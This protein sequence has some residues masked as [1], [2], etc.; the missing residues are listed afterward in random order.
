[1]TILLLH[2]KLEVQRALV[3][4]ALVFRSLEN[5]HPFLRWQLVKILRTHHLIRLSRK[6]LANSEIFLSVVSFGKSAS[7]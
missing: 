6:I 3:E 4:G 2:V 7:I 1:M 5:L